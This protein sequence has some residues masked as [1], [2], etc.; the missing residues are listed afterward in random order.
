MIRSLS[1]ATLTFLRKAAIGEE[2][3]L[4]RAKFCADDGE[5]G[6]GVRRVGF[7]GGDEDDGTAEVEQPFPAG[8]RI[9]RWEL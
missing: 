7:S 1:P 8:S 4:L 3:D 2:D 6:I 9:W 5:H